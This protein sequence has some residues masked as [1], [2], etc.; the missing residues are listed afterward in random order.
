MRKMIT[1]LTMIMWSQFANSEVQVSEA[2]VAE[3]PALTFQESGQI[4]LSVKEDKMTV[5]FQEG[6][7]PREYATKLIKQQLSDRG[8]KLKDGW[9]W[10]PKIF[11]ITAYT[12]IYSEDKVSYDSGM[13]MV[14]DIKPD[15]LVMTSR[16]ASEASMLAY[17][18]PELTKLDIGLMHEGT[19][20]TQAMGS[21][22]GSLGGVALN[23]MINLTRK[24]L[25]NSPSE[26]ALDGKSTLNRE[27]GNCGSA[28]G[29]TH[30]VVTFT[31]LY[32]N[33]FKPI[34]SLSIDKVDNKAN[35]H[36]LLEIAN[37]G[38]QIIAAKLAQVVVKN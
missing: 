30:H 5:F 20:L 29:I 4:D 1:F 23:L 9:I 17:T 25:T 12:H 14:K 27:V 7:S 13:M 33:D 31:V 11:R 2:S 19:K 38:M 3:N 36:N 10:L 26:S 16:H 37:H 34:Y 15:E 35:E 24:A 6:K 32:D 28:C 18:A 21:S 22:A 8:V